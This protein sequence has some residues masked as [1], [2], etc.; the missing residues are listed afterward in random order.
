ML[1]YPICI[2][3]VLIRF[4]IMNMSYHAS[5]FSISYTMRLTPF[6]SFKFKWLNSHIFY[7]LYG[8]KEIHTEVGKHEYE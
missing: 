3:L 8:C 2:Y 5:F 4:E 6:Y 7:E 1:I